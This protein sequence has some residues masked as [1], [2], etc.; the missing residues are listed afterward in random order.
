MN[1]LPVYTYV[2]TAGL[3]LSLYIAISRRRPSKVYPPGPPADPII[4]HAR[5]FPLEYFHTVFAEWGKKYGDIIFVHILGKPVVIVN[6]LEMARDLL[7]KR[8]ANYSD[9]PT[10][11]L[12]DMMNWSR[13][14][15]CLPYGDRW[16]GLRRMIAEKFTPIAVKTFFPVIE[17]EVGDFLRRFETNPLGYKANIHRL[18]SSMTLNLVYGYRV[19]TDNDPYVAAAEHAIYMTAKYVIGAVP[20]DFLPILRFLPEWFPGAGFV[21][22]A[23]E[24]DAVVQ[25]LCDE[26]FNFVQKQKN[27]GTAGPSLMAQWHEE[28]EGSQLAGVSF[29][30]MK[31]TGFCTYIAA[32]ET[33]E[34]TLLT[35]FIMIIHHPNVARVAQSEIDSFI[36][37]EG[38][39]PSLQDRERLPF[40]DCILK[41]TYRV[42]SPAP[43]S[44]PHKS[45]NDDEYNGLFIPGGSMIMPN[46][47]NM[48]NDGRVYPNPSEFNPER[49]RQNGDDAILDPFDV[50]FGFG[51]RICPG[52][53]FADSALWLTITNILAVFD[54]LPPIDPKTGEEVLPKIEFTFGVTIHPKPFDCRVVP[55][56]AN[57]LALLRGSGDL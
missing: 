35:F 21:R 32:V 20:V 22:H 36:A 45:A 38:R 29:D 49:F 28:F 8:G 1:S 25:G 41:E 37:E 51:R 31:L 24:T 44:V 33:T 19:A 52:R 12:Y 55:R 18:F 30:D 39:L 2:A 57:H 13:A 46:I 26:L 43:M 42:C 47:W 16:K 5:I 50:I 17:T 23:N 34:S 40:I 54:I 3:A 4:G 6:S 14:I 48:M 53:H 56:S 11:T 15:F 7:E 27:A 10:S 9:R